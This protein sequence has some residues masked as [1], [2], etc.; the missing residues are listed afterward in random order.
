MNEM[1]ISQPQYLICSIETMPWTVRLGHVQNAHLS[2][3]RL[4]QGGPPVVVI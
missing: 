1:N 2:P 3:A 4:Q